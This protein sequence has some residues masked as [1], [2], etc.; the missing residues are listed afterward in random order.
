MNT[1]YTCNTA[2]EFIPG[3]NWRTTCSRCVDDLRMEMHGGVEGWSP[4]DMAMTRMH[5]YPDPHAMVSTSVLIR[6]NDRWYTPSE[7]AKNDAELIAL[8]R[9]GGCD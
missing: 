2:F 6:E 9:E 5:V 3:R 8:Y 7:V 1:C 4:Q